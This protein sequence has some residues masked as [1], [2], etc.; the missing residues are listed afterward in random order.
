MS[1][2]STQRPQASDSATTTGQRLAKKLSYV[3]EAL[4]AGDIPVSLGH[5]LAKA[6]DK[7]E[8]GLAR[9]R[10]LRAAAALLNPG[11]TLDRWPVA[12]A[13]AS[14][15]KWF[16]DTG[17]LRRVL[18]GHRQPATDLERCLLTILQTPGPRRPYGL[19]RELKALNI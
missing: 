14:A 5:S 1:A 11:N 13:L 3:G 6:V 19:W 17:G 2:L 8:A 9:Q 4:A 12:L 15:L 16:E 10:A 7:V 18:A